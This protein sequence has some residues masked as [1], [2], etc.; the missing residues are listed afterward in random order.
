MSVPTQ[1]SDA[2]LI[3]AK[4]F[5]NYFEVASLTGLPLRFVDS[6][7]ANGTIHAKRVGDRVLIPRHELLRSANVPEEDQR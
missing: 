4:L 5:S 6:L 2:P 7:I 1:P 3:P